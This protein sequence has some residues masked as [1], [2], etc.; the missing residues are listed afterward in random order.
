MLRTTHLLRA[1]AEKAISVLSPPISEDINLGRELHIV[2]GIT[3]SFPIQ[4]LAVRGEMFLGQWN[5]AMNV[6]NFSPTFVSIRLVHVY[7]YRDEMINYG[8]AANAKKINK[9][10]K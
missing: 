3:A 4:L 9:C 7:V 1:L 5:G 8:K 10:D 2:A 6:M